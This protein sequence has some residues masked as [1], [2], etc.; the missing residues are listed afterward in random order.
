MVHP[1]EQPL[2]SEQKRPTANGGALVFGA[3]RGV[4]DMKTLRV[5]ALSKE[6]I[7]HLIPQW[8]PRSLYK[9]HQLEAD[10]F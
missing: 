5:N 10:R 2:V 4:D 9:V 6:P 1:V 3:L 8:H 7:H